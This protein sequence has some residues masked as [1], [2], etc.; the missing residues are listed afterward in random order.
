MGGAP[1][2][3]FDADLNGVGGANN[4]THC[5]ETLVGWYREKDRDEFG[6]YYGKKMGG[7]IG[8]S[9]DAPSSSYSP[10]PSASLSSISAQDYLLDDPAQTSAAVSAFDTPLNEDWHNT[11]VERLNKRNLEFAGTLLQRKATVQK[12]E[13]KTVTGHGSGVHKEHKTWNAKSYKR[14]HGKTA[15]ELNQM[16]GLNRSLKIREAHRNQH[17]HR[18]E[19]AAKKGPLSFLQQKRAIASQKMR[20]PDSFDWADHG[21]LDQ[22]VNQG[23]CGS[24]YTVATVRMLSARNRVRKADNNAGPF[25]IN[26]P[27]HCAEYNQGC[28]GGYAFLQSKWSEDVGLIPAACFPYNTAGSCSDNID[29][30]CIKAHGGAAKAKNHR[31]VGGYYGGSD[32]EDIKEEL[33]RGGPIVVSFEPKD[34]FMYY[35]NGIYTSNLGDSIHQEW[36][37]VDHAVLLVGYGEEQGKKF[38]RIQN[39]WGDDWGENGYFRIARGDNDSGVESIAVASDV[40]DSDGSQVESFLNNRI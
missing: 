2:G 20:L 40:E 21:V 9:V 32:E 8:N 28:D 36:E 1:T 17:R 19:S 4:Q 35:H 30:Q 18:P 39:S 16:A 27:L 29:P 12:I 38:W 37:K 23:D 33:V 3:D 26:F 13:H 31:Y 34:D 25:S 11:V 5:E 6:C 24:C 15:R 14:F 7:G 22:V 10:A